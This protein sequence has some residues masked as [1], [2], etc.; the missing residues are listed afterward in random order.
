[1]NV[2]YFDAVS[3]STQ[4][5]RMIRI[6]VWCPFTKQGKLKVI[7][8]TRW[9][10]YFRIEGDMAVFSIGLHHTPRRRKFYTK[11]RF[12]VL[13]REIRTKNVLIF[14][15]DAILKTRT[16][17]A[18]S[19]VQIHLSCFNE[20]PKISLCCL[21]FWCNIWKN[22]EN[23]IDLKTITSKGGEQSSGT[24]PKMLHS[25][26][27]NNQLIVWFTKEIFNTTG[28]YCWHRLRYQQIKIKRMKS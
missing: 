20:R 18:T 4:S 5:F 10:W 17:I 9:Q 27:Q 24:K 12:L 8:L 16:A 22:F 26:K 1:M 15:R 13:E 3:S 21:L 14:Q 7:K 6:A 25:W 11:L 19:F 23:C 2:V 28:R